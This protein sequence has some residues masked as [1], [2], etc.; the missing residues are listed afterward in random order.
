MRASYST[1]TQNSETWIVTHPDIRLRATGSLRHVVGRGTLALRLGVGPTF[2]RELR[3][4]NQAMREG[5]TDLNTRAWGTVPAADLEAVFAVHVA[6]PWLATA[7]GGPSLDYFGGGVNVGW[8]ATL[9][10]AWQP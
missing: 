4:R 2:V 10:V 8:L 9:G 1:T 3:E 7:S 5:R 6:G